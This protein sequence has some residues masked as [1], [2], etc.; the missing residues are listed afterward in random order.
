MKIFVLSMSIVF[1]VC[2]LPLSGGE[3]IFSDCLTYPLPTHTIPSFSEDDPPPWASGNF[4]GEWGISILGLPAV[5][6]GWV[7]GYFSAAGVS[8]RIEGVF[9]EYGV[10]EPT[11]Y[12]EGIVL[13]FNMIGVV[14]D[15][16]TGN[17]TFFMGLGA[18]NENGEFYYR[19]S[20]I[21]GPSF[22][23]MGTWAEFTH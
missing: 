1:L 9:S 8:G 10:E 15:I 16:E 21:I 23:M 11:A 14:G 19:I 17:G 4:S 18:P 5:P 20:L 2:C 12:I 22:Y 7:E 3:S 13:L 6:L